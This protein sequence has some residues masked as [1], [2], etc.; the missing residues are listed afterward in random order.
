MW[1][2]TQASPKELAQAL[3]LENSTISGVLD[4]MQKKGLIDRLLDS[5]DR[6]SIQVV[7]TPE[8]SELKDDVLKVIE[9]VNRQ[10]LGE[11]DEHTAEMLISCL[12]KIGKVQ[13]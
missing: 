6:R 10:V 12:Q 1:E 9:E 13:E 2:T 3:S 5:N 8:G 11:F 4:R 7:L